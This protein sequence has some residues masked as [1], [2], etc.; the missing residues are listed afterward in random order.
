MAGIPPLVGFF[1]KY[2]VLTSA[3]HSGH[4]FVAIVAILASVVSA[5]YYLR[6]VRV[7]YF[8]QP[9]G[10]TPGDSEFGAVVTSTHSYIIAALTA[11]I[12]LFGLDPSLIL[13]TAELMG[14]TLAGY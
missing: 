5:V 11:L 10:Y 12:L 4:N 3:I 7:L 14:V 8:D 6:V 9:A 13:N 1:G 2:L